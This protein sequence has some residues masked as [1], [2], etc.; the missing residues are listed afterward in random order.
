MHTPSLGGVVAIVP[1]VDKV[2]ES[3]VLMIEGLEHQAADT[4]NK[5]AG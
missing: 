5:E 1:G 2:R 3:G 4:D